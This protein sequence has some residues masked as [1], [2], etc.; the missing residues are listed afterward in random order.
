MGP[1]EDLAADMVADMVRP[2]EDVAAT[3]MRP[4]R[5]EADSVLRVA[6]AV[7]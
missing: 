6:V 4:T 7:P 5:H 3:E 1:V 2:V